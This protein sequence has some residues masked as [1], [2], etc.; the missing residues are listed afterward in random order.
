MVLEH[1]NFDTGEPCAGLK[2][3][4]APASTSALMSALVQRVTLLHL[5]RKNLSY[6]TSKCS[7]KHLSNVVM[8]PLSSYWSSATA[9][10]RGADACA[11]RATQGELG[12]SRCRSQRVR[13]TDGESGEGRTQPGGIR[14]ENLQRTSQNEHHIST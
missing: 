6:G 7:S 1:Y 8:V 3:V 10:H 4:A 9:N 2:A 5:F 13:E 12:Q 11:F 14:G